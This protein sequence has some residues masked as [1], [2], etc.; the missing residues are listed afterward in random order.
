M[1][2]V[3]N[4][5]KR[6]I[7]AILM[8]LLLVTSSTVVFALP[9]T[10]WDIDMT[11]PVEGASVQGGATYTLAVNVTDSGTAVTDATAGATVEAQV[12]LFADAAAAEAATPDPAA[13]QTMTYNAA[14]GQ[15]ELTYAAP[16][17]DANTTAMLFVRVSDGTA[18]QE[19]DFTFFLLPIAPSEGSGTHFLRYDSATGTYKLEWQSPSPVDPEG[20]LGSVSIVALDSAG[21]E[22]AAFEGGF[23]MHPAERTYLFQDVTT[24]ARLRGGVVVEPVDPADP[25]AGNEVGI[26]F[27]GSDL[28]PGAVYTLTVSDGVNSESV[29]FTAA[30]DQPQ[31]GTGSTLYGPAATALEANETNFTISVTGP[32]FDASNGVSG[33][34]DVEPVEQEPIVPHEVTGDGATMTIL[35]PGVAL[36]GGEPTIEVLAKNLETFEVSVTDAGGNPITDATVILGITYE[37]APGGPPA[38]GTTWTTV[39]YNPADNTYTVVWSIPP[40]TNAEGMLGSMHVRVIDVTTGEELLLFNAGAEF[41][42][43][44]REF[45]F[46]DAFTDERLRGEAVVE[47]VDPA[48]PNSSKELGV[49]FGGDKL[50]AGETYTLTITDG[51]VTEEVNFTS[52]GTGRGGTVL[53][54][55]VTDLNADENTWTL[56]VNGGGFSDVSEG[57]NPPEEVEAVTAPPWVEVSNNGLFNLVFDSPVMV[58]EGGVAMVDGAAKQDV[59]VQMRLVDRNTGGTVIDARHGYEVQWQATLE[60]VQQT[61]DVVAPPT[62]AFVGMTFNETTGMWEATEPIAAVHAAAAEHIRYELALQYEDDD[63]GVVGSLVYPGGN[64]TGDASIALTEPAPANGTV[65]ITPGQALGLVASATTTVTVTEANSTNTTT[66][67]VVLN[68]SVGEMQYRVT[69]YFEFVGPLTA[70]EPPADT[71]DTSGGPA[72]PPADTGDSGG[73]AAPPANNGGGSGDGSGGSGGGSG[74][75]GGAA[76]TPTPEPAPDVVEPEPDAVEPE[77]DEF[78]PSGTTAVDPVPDATAEFDLENDEPADQEPAPEPAEDVDDDEPAEDIEEPAPESGSSVV[79]LLIIA[80]LIIAL[81]AGVAVLARP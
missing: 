18:V 46:R 4:A 17:V 69:P 66:E 53:A 76:P 32:E 80:A 74:G 34:G 25:T 30:G 11:S 75:S 16:M 52:D 3:R 55:T 77:Q 31:S 8:V 13:Y 1:S 73:P 39:P 28:T 15:W 68:D 43:A 9:A 60:G 71:G 36:E 6:G 45:G 49:A 14:S 72:A 65:T 58:P 50:V 79:V 21:T 62:P 59:V 10:E 2:P 5:Q 61:G 41:H 70:P 47:P 12:G 48:D 33:P 44:G 24:S 63:A 35:S 20:L 42:T 26:S 23:G 29:N 56:T 81:V 64:A 57:P 22:L 51:T 38:P 19:K 7:G 54:P 78:V 27:S 67:T 37:T 40:T